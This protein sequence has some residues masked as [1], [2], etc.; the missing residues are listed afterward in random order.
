[1]EAIN[2]L[3][4]FY[5]EKKCNNGVVYKSDLPFFSDHEPRNQN[6]R[7]VKIFKNLIKRI[8]KKIV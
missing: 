1:M 4:K 3:P 5:P 8:L 6:Q 2:D 7:D